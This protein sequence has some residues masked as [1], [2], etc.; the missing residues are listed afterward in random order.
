MHLCLPKNG[1]RLEEE[2]EK[3]SRESDY[4]ILYLVYMFKLKSCS[5]AQSGTEIECTSGVKFSDSKIGY[6]HLD[7]KNQF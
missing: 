4:T 1:R 2:M 6:T 3:A 7:F 5:L